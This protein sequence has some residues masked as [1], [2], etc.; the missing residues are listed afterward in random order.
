L[1]D[2]GE[3]SSD[4]FSRSLGLHTSWFVRQT[5]QSLA[6]NMMLGIFAPE[7]RCLQHGDH[8]DEISCM[9]QQTCQP[10]LLLSTDGSVQ[11]DAWMK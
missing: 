3:C 11:T 4:I 1:R 9:Q 2:G 10:L 7:R 5:K 8:S 6:L